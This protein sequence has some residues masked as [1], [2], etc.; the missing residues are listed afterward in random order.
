MPYTNGMMQYLSF[1]SWYTFHFHCWCHDKTNWT[2]SSLGE[3]K[4]YLAHTSRPQSIT[5]KILGR[6]SIKRELD[7]ETVEEL[8][9][10]ACSEDHASLFSLWQCRTTCSWMLLPTVSLAN[11]ISYQSRQSLTDTSSD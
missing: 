2:Q 5:E 7:A 4:V 1:S 3:E 10:L 11:Y 6:N 9:F 8:C